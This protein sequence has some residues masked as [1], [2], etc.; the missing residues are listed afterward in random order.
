MSQSQKRVVKP[1]WWEQKPPQ[2][3]LYPLLIN[4][5]EY[6]PNKNMKEN[7]RINQE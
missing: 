4:H 5:S 2:K 7:S 1:K 3:K 6:K